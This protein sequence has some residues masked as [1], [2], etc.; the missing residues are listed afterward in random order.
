MQTVKDLILKTDFDL[1]AKD[2]E[3]HHGNEHI[4]K[5]KLIYDQLSTMSSKQNL[6]N[7]M[8]FIRALKENEQ[9]DE[10]VVVEHFD[11]NDTTLWFDVCGQDNNYDGLYSISSSD[12]AEL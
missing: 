9:G 3:R 7:M 10:D 2:I 12:Y 1:I 8:L 11:S 6:S 5:I 4:P